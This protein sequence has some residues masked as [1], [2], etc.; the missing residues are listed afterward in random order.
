MT[1]P[2]SES[3]V[4]EVQY[5]YCTKYAN[6]TS[7]SRILPAMICSEDGILSVIEQGEEPVE[8]L[9]E[10]CAINSFDI[11]RQN[12]SDVV[13]ALEWESIAILSRP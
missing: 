9:A 11:D 12:P 7:S 4:W 8:L 6:N 2:V 10:A 1:Q 3:E 13:C 5:D